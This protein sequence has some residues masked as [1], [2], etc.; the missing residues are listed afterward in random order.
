MLYF[1]VWASLFLSSIQEQNCQDDES[2]TLS[3]QYFWL[4][5][6][7]MSCWIVFWDY[8]YVAPG[9]L[10]S[11]PLNVRVDYNLQH[12]RIYVTWKD[13]PSTYRVPDKRIYDVA[14]LLTH[15]MK[16]VYNVNVC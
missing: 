4:I 13:D 12:Q 9:V 3:F 2:K 15:N 8:T 5:Q 16:E 1:L 14:V 11:G 7:C 6:Y 10:L